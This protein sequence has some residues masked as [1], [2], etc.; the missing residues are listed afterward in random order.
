MMKSPAGILIFAICLIS[1][2]I[3]AA[4][5]RTADTTIEVGAHEDV[6]SIGKLAGKDFDWVPAE[7][8]VPALSFPQNVS[9]NGKSVVVAWKLKNEADLKRPAIGHVFTFIAERPELELNSTWI[10]FTGPGPVEH[11]LAITNRSSQPVLVPLPP[12]LVFGTG[13]SSENWWVEKGAG[14]P[15]NAGIHHVQVTK[16]FSESLTSTPYAGENPPEPVPWT[17]IYDSSHRR[18]WYVGVESSARVRIS[19]SNSP[20]GVLEVNAGPAAEPGE[21]TRIAPGE[22]VRFPR[23][24]VGCFEGDVDDGCNRLRRWVQSNV[25]P[26]VRD[27]R[28]PL[29]VN[30]SWGSGMQVDEP[31]AKKMIDDSADLGLEL[32]HIDAGWFRGVGDW[33]T[34][35]KKFPNGLASIADYTH[36]KGLKFGLWVGWTQGG[37]DREGS[38]PDRPLSVFDPERKDWFPKDADPKWKPTDFTGKTVCLGDPPAV[39]WCL[40]QLR[41]IVKEYKLDLLEHDQEMV[42]SNCSRMDHLHTNSATDASFRS[43]E[44]YYKVYD[45][46][47]AENPELLFEDC[48]NGGRMVDYGVLRRCHYVSI[49]DTYDPLSNRRAFYDASYV[50]PPS[51]CECYIENQKVSSLK[52]FLFMLRSGM[53]GWCTIMADTSRWT[54]EQHAAAKHQF[55]LYKKTLRP[56]INHADLYHVSERPDGGRWDGIEYWDA[57][58]GKGVLFAFRDKNDEADHAFVLRGLAEEERYHLTSEDGSVAEANLSGKILRTEGLKVHLADPQ[59]SDLIFI[60]RE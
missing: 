19:L 36:S 56:L 29:L 42:I 52:G 45:T 57:E 28:Y 60:T 55:D 48:V 16:D 38:G 8:G 26:P 58:S 53:M 24:F 22:T 6:L 27:E 39:N 7:R 32:Y 13:F 50:L 54:P 3:F 37:D 46:L 59:T 43:A 2:P 11:E 31:L 21:F 4:T 17:A 15:T 40:D 20:A 47:R 34:D 9:V 25:R 12:T 14:H 18:G 35:P 44:G 1:P 23:A 51:M 10:G 41:R 5:I 33:Q 49:T 30:N